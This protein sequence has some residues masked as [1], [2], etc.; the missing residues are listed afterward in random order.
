MEGVRALVALL[1]TAVAVAAAP[2]LIITTIS[3]LNNI[4][5]NYQY[6]YIIINNSSNYLNVSRLGVVVSPY[7]AKIVYA[8]ANASYPPPLSIF[9]TI[10]Y[11]NA[12]L[13]NNLLISTNYSLIKIKLTIK[14]YMPFGVP[15]TVIVQ[16][17]PDVDIIA[18]EPPTS[19]ESLGS[20]T[21]YQWSYFIQNN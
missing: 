8:A 10:T 19:I 14:N 21:I 9:Y 6:M 3:S 5:T 17:V 16:K 11:I 2:T 4:Q 18:S 12:T 7:S 15:A 1:L 13:F 20:S